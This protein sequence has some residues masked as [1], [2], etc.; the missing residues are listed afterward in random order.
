M[1]AD[2]STDDAIVLGA[3]YND[4]AGQWEW[5]NG[6]VAQFVVNNF[7]YGE[8]NNSGHC[9]QMFASPGFGFDDMGCGHHRVYVC[10]K[11]E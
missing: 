6:N 8:P 1:I 5:T 4:V 2:W 10:Q 7:A 11:D 9:L 3:G